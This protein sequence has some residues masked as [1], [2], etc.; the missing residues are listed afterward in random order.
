VTAPGLRV[1]LAL[2]SAAAV[3]VAIAAVSVIAWWATAG[4]M[5]GQ[6][7]DALTGTPLANRVQ[8]TGDAVASPELLCRVPR[9]AVAT[10]F[11]ADAGGMQ[12]IRADGTSC[13]LSGS[14]AVPPT[15]ADIAVA[16]GGPVTGL[17]NT[18][19]DTGVHVRAVTY[20]VTDGYALMVWR[21]LTE[22]DATLRRLALWLLLAGGLGVGGALTAGWIVART[23]LRPLDR[24][25]DAAEHVA[26]TR[27]LQVP[28]EVRGN[29]EVARLARAFNRMTAALELARQRQKQMIDDAGH[30]L[31]TPLTSLRTNIELL[32]RSEDGARQLAPADRRDLLASVSAQVQELSVLAGEL[33]LLTHDEPAV[34]PVPLRLDEVAARAVR[35]ASRRGRHPVVTD[36]RPWHVVGDPAA[37]ERAVLN[38]VD[39]A[40]KFSPPGSTVTVRLRGGRLDVADEGPGIPEDERGQVFERFWRSP[41]ARALPGSGLG[42]AIVADVVTG[43]GGTVEAGSSPA[44]GATFTVRL[45]GHA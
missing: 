34:E 17:R 44:G 32:V 25:T 14:P 26:T 19:T 23:G 12:L 15:A 37:L 30:E 5:R 21:D 1:R 11:R 28:I 20:P 42:L 9:A 27:D 41:A 18:D 45:P 24:L 3:A 43:H 38:L 31:R 33:T 39:N 4:T 22:M 6:I 29:D 35:R 13:A 2:I 36:L 10:L 7:D 8:R 40:I 16:A